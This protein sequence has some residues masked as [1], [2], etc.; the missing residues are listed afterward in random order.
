MASFTCIHFF[1]PYVQSPSEELPNANV[2]LTTTSRL[3]IRLISH[4]VTR[5]Q[6]T[7]DHATACQPMPSFVS[8]PKW[9]CVYENS[10]N[11]WIVN[12]T[13]LSNQ[14]PKNI[15][16]LHYL[17]IWLNLPAVFAIGNS[18]VTVSRGSFTHICVPASHRSIGLFMWTPKHI[19][20]FQAVF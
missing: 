15:S 3:F 14:M 20:R 16:S 12:A 19:F 17:W 10:C 13:V 7:F 9:V 4:K 5:K 8:P 2:T 1:G 11:S 6:V 18:W